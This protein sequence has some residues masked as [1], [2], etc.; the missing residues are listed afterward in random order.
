MNRQAINTDAAPRPVGPYSQSVAARGLLFI[1][2]QMGVDPK[3]VVIGHVGNLVDPNVEVHRAICRRGAFIGFDRQGGAGDTQQVPMVM[4]LIEA[5]YADNLMFA[6]DLSNISFLRWCMSS[7]TISSSASRSMR[8]LLER[9]AG[10][11]PV[12]R[13]PCLSTERASSPISPRPPPPNATSGRRP[14]GRR[15]ETVTGTV[16][17]GTTIA[18]PWPDW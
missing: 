4:K 11:M 15:K 14:R 17:G 5:G 12:T 1:A 3:K 13:P 18:R 6:S 9:N 8:S 16:N 10:M 2:G 7:T